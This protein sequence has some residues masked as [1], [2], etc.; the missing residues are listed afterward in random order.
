MNAFFQESVEQIPSQSPVVA[1]EAIPHLRRL[2]LPLNQSGLLQLFEVLRHRRL[3]N[4]QFLLD[5]AELASILPGQKLKNGHAGRVPHRFGEPRQLLLLIRIIFCAHRLRFFISFA[6]LRT[7]T[8][9]AKQISHH[10]VHAP[11]PQ[12][13]YK[14]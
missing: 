6:K 7:T 13:I 9:P 1:M 12:G 2:D 5:V 8:R 10:F 11:T 4:R 3:R 14:R